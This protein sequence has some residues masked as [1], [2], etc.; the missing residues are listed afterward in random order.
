MMPQLIYYNPFY[1]TFDVTLRGRQPV[2]TQSLYVRG[3]VTVMSEKKEAKAQIP[4]V[5]HMAEYT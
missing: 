5:H 4:K 1:S 3:E 2:F